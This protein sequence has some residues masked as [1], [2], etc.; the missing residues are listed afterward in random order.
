M[1][2]ISSLRKIVEALDDRAETVEPGYRSIRVRND[3][4]EEL[5]VWK[6]QWADRS[7]SDAL[8]RVF[9]LAK[10]ELLILSEDPTK[11]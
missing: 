9:S 2:P 4:Y 11:E 10:S 8:K 7:I 5:M 6:D 1:D 3:V